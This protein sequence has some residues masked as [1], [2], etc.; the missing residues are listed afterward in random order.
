MRDWANETGFDG[1]I[2]YVFESGADGEVKAVDETVHALLGTE[3]M[4]RVFR[5]GRHVLARKTEALQLQSADLLAW[6]WF[7]HNRRIRE[8]TITKRA[9]FK[10][11]IGLKIDPHHYDASSIELW[12][13]VQGPIMKQVFRQEKTHT[14]IRV[15]LEALGRAK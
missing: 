9:D 12:Q 14:S 2:E 5:Y 1:E 3:Q 11:L 7:T 15:L 6:H 4:R 10:N 8:G 13:A